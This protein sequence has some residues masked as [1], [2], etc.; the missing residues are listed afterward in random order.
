MISVSVSPASAMTS[1]SGMSNMLHTT[2][3]CFGKPTKNSN[4]SNCDMRYMNLSFMDL[5][6]INLS[7]ANMK[8]MKLYATNL[9]GTNVGG[10]NTAGADLSCTGNPICRG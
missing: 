10:L 6:G 1:M 4:W 7:G 5:S 3:V 9:S 2:K 8:G